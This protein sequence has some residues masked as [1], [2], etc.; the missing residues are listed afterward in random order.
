MEPNEQTAT[1]ARAVP[2]WEKTPLTPARKEE[3]LKLAVET[4]AR[5]KDL[6]PREMS[7][8]SRAFDLLV[9]N[10]H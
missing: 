8:Y 9:N 4:A 5:L 7:F 3:L 10:Y 2:E 6:N 1:M